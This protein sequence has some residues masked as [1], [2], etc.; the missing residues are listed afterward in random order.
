MKLHV[1]GSSSAGNCYLI[2]DSRNQTLIIEAGIEFIKVERALKWDVRN[3]VGTIITHTH[4]DHAK[5]VCHHLDAGVPTFAHKSV[6]ENRKIKNVFARPQ[7]DGVWTAEIGPYKVK[8]LPVEH[9]VPCY[10][11]LIHHREGKIFFVTDTMY[12][13]HNRQGYL[14]PSCD[15]ALLEANYD[16]YTLNRNIDEGITEAGMV[17][18]LKLSHMEFGT[19]KELIRT[20]EGRV[21]KIVLTHLSAKNSERL[22]YISEVQ[23]MS[24]IPTYVASKNLT[25]DF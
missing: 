10:C 1:L 2:T 14:L 17:P 15:L 16:D 13:G 5:Y 3:V 21:G 19:T 7:E 9:D 24:A 8:A 23:E 6:F 20:R 18:R 25:L 12:C 4:N 22:R 11:F